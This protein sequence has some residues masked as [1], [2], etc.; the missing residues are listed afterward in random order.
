[1]QRVKIVQNM[2][3]FLLLAMFLTSSALAAPL[4]K[5]QVAPSPAK[6][7]TPVMAPSVAA[8]PDVF[9]KNIQL[10]PAQPKV[11]ENFEVHIELFNKGK[12]VTGPGQKCLVSIVPE[13]F[14]P[15]PFLIEGSIA[16]NQS[17]LI[18]K[19]HVLST[20]GDYTVQARP[21]PGPSNA[22]IKPFVVVP[23]AISTQPEPAGKQ[24]GSGGTLGGDKSTKAEEEEE[25]LTKKLL[26][27]GTIK[28]FDPQP[29]PPGKE[30]LTVPIQY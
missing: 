2:G 28:K 11:G 4:V 1:M 15:D 13:T 8:I 29:E 17:K 21:I 3:C 7:A 24:L 23:T 22:V 5:P 25:I 19:K 20:A 26:L 30:S 12:G 6:I 16:P 10:V 14:T 27:P 18:V 9:V